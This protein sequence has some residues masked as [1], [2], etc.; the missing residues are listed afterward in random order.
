MSHVDVGQ[1]MLVRPGTKSPWT[2][3]FTTGTSDVNQAWLTGE[4]IPVDKKPGDVI[5]A[6]TINGRGAL[7]AVVTHTSATHGTGPDHRAGPQ[8][9]GIQVERAAVGGPRGQLVRSRRADH[10]RTHT[11]R[12]AAA[13]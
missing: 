5:Y 3:A 9:P 6:G 12:V 7:Q 10:R 4:S 1:M 8:G 11:R 13:G 2:C